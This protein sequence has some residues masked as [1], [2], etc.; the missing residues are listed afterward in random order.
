MG[1]TN[2]D[3]EIEA[4]DTRIAEIKADKAAIQKYAKVAKAIE[5]METTD[6][7]KLAIET[8]FLND[9]SERLTNRLTEGDYLQKNELEVIESSLGVIRGYKTFIK[10]VKNLG[11]ESKVKLIACDAKIA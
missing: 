8:A 10:Q 2:R 3:A 7:Y 11:K 9:E 6:N 4:I 1:E 5:E